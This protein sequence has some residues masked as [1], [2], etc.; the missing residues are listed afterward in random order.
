MITRT[1]LFLI[2]CICLQKIEAQQKQNGNTITSEIESTIIEFIKQSYVINSDDWDK[3]K[4]YI[5][6]NL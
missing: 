4:K 5:R 1:I 6:K 2:F 3:N